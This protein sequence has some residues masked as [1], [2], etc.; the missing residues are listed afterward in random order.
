MTRLIVGREWPDNI[1]Q[2]FRTFKCSA[3]GC[4]KMAAMK[5]HDP[6]L[7]H[8]SNDERCFCRDH[9]LAVFKQAQEQGY[10]AR[11]NGLSP[12]EW[13]DIVTIWSSKDHYLMRRRQDAV[14]GWR[15]WEYAEIV[16][17]ADYVERACP[18][19]WALRD[20]DGNFVIRE[21]P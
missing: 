7:R 13:P 8:L 16:T 14:G 11:H 15:G 6:T 19:P 5:V 1:P 20:G 2:G 21:G 17:A 10:R 12:V 3:P 9:G 18:N 4:R